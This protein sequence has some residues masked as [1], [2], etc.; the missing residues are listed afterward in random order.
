MKKRILS[1][2]LVLAMT[3]SLVACGGGNTASPTPSDADQSTGDAVVST[4]AGEPAASG[5]KVTITMYSGAADAELTAMETLVN[6]YN[7]ENTDNIIVELT[8]PADY[9]VV[10]KTM[11]AS[12]NLPDIF[13]TH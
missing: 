6:K 8:C 13:F 3:I 2:L 5:D 12:N 9:E 10:L 7:A 11:M 1:S 4:E